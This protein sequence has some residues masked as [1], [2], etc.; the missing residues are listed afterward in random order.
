MRQEYQCPADGHRPEHDEEHRAEQQAERQKQPH[1]HR[2]DT[3]AA[4]TDW[5][6]Q[7]SVLRG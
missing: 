7:T 6:E 4:G 1:A 3:E 5:L 2:Q